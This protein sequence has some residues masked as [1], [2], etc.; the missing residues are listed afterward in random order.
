MAH[1][2]W[3]YLVYQKRDAVELISF[4]ENPDFE[5]KQ[6]AQLINDT[7]RDRMYPEPDR[8]LVSWNYLH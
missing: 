6:F 7:K 3:K 5:L 8:D 4:I 1:K 2:V